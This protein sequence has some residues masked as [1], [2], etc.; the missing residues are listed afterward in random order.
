MT[1]YSIEKL[2][3]YRYLHVIPDPWSVPFR[4][5]PQECAGAYNPA[6]GWFRFP[7]CFPVT[8]V[9][10]KFSTTDVTTSTKPCEVCF[11]H[12]NCISRENFCPLPQ[13]ELPRM[14]GILHGQRV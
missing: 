6:S 5:L 13:P 9:V 4:R 10:K 3:F 7:L 12:W 1:R 8:S 11:A 2:S 14:V